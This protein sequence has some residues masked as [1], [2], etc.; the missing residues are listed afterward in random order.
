MV[1]M[2]AFS[3]CVATSTLLDIIQGVPVSSPPC[4]REETR[5]LEGI[6]SD[7]FFYHMQLSSA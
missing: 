1:L 7:A 6:I 2:N 5:A 3:P 4:T